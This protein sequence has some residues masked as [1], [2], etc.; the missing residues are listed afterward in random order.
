M[1]A[2]EPVPVS[3]TEEQLLTCAIGAVRR[4]VDNMV[5][6]RPQPY[7]EPDNRWEADV[8]GACGEFV[9]AQ[10]LGMFWDPVQ[11]FPQKDR[12][13][14]FHVQVRTTKLETGCLFLYPSDAPAHPY[15]LVTGWVPNLVI[16]GFIFGHDGKNQD[17]WGKARTRSPCFA[18]PQYA[19]EDVRRLLA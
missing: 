5:N 12:D 17:Y 13:V 1:S 4:T 14:G 2:P 18:V 10:F 15:V 3:L 9:V 6:R 11:G 19:L 7:G 8:Q 16:R